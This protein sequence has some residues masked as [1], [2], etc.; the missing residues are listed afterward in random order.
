MKEL[1]AV[2][3]PD[4]RMR[5]TKREGNF[6]RVVGPA[7]CTMVSSIPWC[8]SARDATRL[9]RLRHRAEASLLEAEVGDATVVRDEAALVQ[10]GAE[11][12]RAPIRDH[13]HRSVAI[14]P[15]VNEK[16]STPGSRNSISNCRSTIGFGCRIS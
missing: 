4:D 6:S 14:Q 13:V 5:F 8:R 11:A 2:R 1:S 10:F 12:A 15:K 16:T 7:Y 9:L 3:N